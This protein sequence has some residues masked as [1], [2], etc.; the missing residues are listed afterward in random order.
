MFKTTPAKTVVLGGQEVQIYEPPTILGPTDGVQF[1]GH[2][3]KVVGN[4]V[5]ATICRCGGGKLV[6][7]IAEDEPDDHG[8][9]RIIV[10]CYECKCTFMSAYPEGVEKGE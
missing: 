4:A 7:V 10:K 2:A 9:K 5:F 8:F 6:N 3:A 1:A